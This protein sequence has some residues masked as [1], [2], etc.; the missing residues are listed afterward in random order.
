LAAVAPLGEHL[1]GVDLTRPWQR[2]EDLPVRVLPEVG[3][4]RAGQVLDRGVQRPQDGH[5]GEHGI[6]QRLG[7]GLA[8]RP[9]RGRAEAFQELGG[10]P[11]AALAV[12]CLTRKAAIRFSP[13]WRANAGVG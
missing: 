11:P 3:G 8:G 6:V 10:G 2:R 13:R 9:G 4:G 12:P 1:G 5:E 7:D